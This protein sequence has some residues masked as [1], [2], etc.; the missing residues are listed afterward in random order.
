MQNHLLH[1]VL[2]LL[3]IYSE[4]KYILSSNLLPMLYTWTDHI[5]FLVL[6]VNEFSF[7]TFSRSCCNLIINF[8]RSIDLF[9]E[10]NIVVLQMNNLYEIYR[11]QMQIFLLQTFFL[12]VLHLSFCLYLLLCTLVQMR[13]GMLSIT[14]KTFN[15]YIVFLYC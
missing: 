12:L 15:L 11:N 13:H 7:W 2:S 8:F 3:N 6:S 10:C 9:S 5:F 4:V 1:Q 14:C